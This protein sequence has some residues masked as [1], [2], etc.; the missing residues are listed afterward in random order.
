MRRHWLIGTLLLVPATLAAQGRD[1]PPTVA[2]DATASVERTPDRAVLTLAVESEA[3]SAQAASQA[4]AQAMAKVI[5]AL[6]QAGL[7]GPAVRTLS[8]RLSPVYSPAP[9]GRQEPPVITG[10][11]AINMV[12]AIVDSLAR[13]GAVVDAAIAAGA[14]R[15]ANL[16][17]ELKN[18]EEARLA[19][20]TAA[21]DQAK[22][23]AETVARAAGR[24]LGPPLEI[25]LSGPMPGP[26]P[27]FAERGVAMA[28]SMETPVEA[29]PL[30]VMATVH[31]VYRLDP[32]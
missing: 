14:N 13:T 4:N 12:E 18:P 29:G 2:V 8:I 27:M 20:L 24:I 32:P 16:S 31:V 7:Q 17:F 23:E 3:G 10:Y 9:A 28:Q 6:R 21:M 22:R 11:R 1:G 19:A 15:V 30:T 25:S 5:A 26:R